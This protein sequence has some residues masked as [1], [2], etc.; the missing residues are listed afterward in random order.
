MSERI[1]TLESKYIIRGKI[2]AETGLHIGGTSSGLSIGSADSTVIRHPISDE[3]FIPGSSIKGK[4]RSLTE[5]SYGEVGQTKMGA[6]HHG[7]SEKDDKLPGML[8]GTSNNTATQHPSRI[9]V[10]DAMLSEEGKDLFRN[11]PFTEVKT[12]VVIDRITS[13]AMPRQVERVP[14]GA[15]FDLNIVL[16]VFKEEKDNFQAFDG[17]AIDHVLAALQL[18]QDDYVGGNGSRG[19]GQISIQIDDIICREAA[20][21]RGTKSEENK[22]DEFRTKFSA[23]F[24]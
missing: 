7:A 8:F 4:M 13:K 6:V 20:Y 22:T 16:N 2:K 24:E 14:S 17:A 18:L 1:L 12:E 9:I 23:L 5:L 11:T 21:Y 3:P 15:T 10:R 19:Y